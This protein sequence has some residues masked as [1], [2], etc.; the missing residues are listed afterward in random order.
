[1]NLL[2]VSEVSREG[3][4]PHREALTEASHL[5]VCICRLLWRRKTE[6]WG[7][8]GSKVFLPEG[9]TPLHPVGQP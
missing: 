1:M 4:V 5:G 2:C 6:V 7:W 3:L 8:S 9:D